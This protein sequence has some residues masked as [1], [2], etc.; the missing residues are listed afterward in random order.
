MLTLSTISLDSRTDLPKVRYAT[1]L[2]WFLL[3]SF[4][5]CIATLL[6]FAG[7]HYFTKVS[8]IFYD[9]NQKRGKC[10]YSVPITTKWRLHPLREFDWRWI[11]FVY[12]FHT[13]IIFIITNT[14]NKYLKKIQ[15]KLGI[16]FQIN[17]FQKL[18]RYDLLNFNN[19]LCILYK[20]LI[21]IAPET[22]LFVPFFKLANCSFSRCAFG[23]FMIVLLAC[24][25]GLCVWNF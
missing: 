3:M 11:F 2:D 1:A 15:I 13:N 25:G 6:E 24:V 14:I 7:V 16:F 10:R 4:F 23:I 20:K 8:F 18:I 19:T 21:I 5:Y 12:V 22:W 17:I 9:F